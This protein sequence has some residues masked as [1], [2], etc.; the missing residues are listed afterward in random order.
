MAI[1][2]PALRDRLAR[3]VGAG[4][5]SFDTHFIA[6]INN[7]I[8][9]FNRQCTGIDPHRRDRAAANVAADESSDV[10]ILSDV[11]DDDVVNGEAAVAFQDDASGQL[12]LDKKF[13]FLFYIGCLYYLGISSEWSKQP[14]EKTADVYKRALAMAQFESIN[15]ANPDSGV[16]STGS[17]RRRS[18]N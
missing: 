10:T 12:P 13:D 7:V 17:H 11:D 9:D 2:V 14:S 6:A 8:G 16:P 18:G 15:E 5:P 4:G 3:S 1:S